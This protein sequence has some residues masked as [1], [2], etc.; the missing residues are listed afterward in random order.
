MYISPF[1]RGIIGLKCS[2]KIILEFPFSRPASYSVNPW[3]VNHLIDEKYFSFLFIMVFVWTLIFYHYSFLVWFLDHYQTC[4]F[5]KTLFFHFNYYQKL[6]IFSP[7]VVDFFLL[8][9]SLDSSA[10]SSLRYHLLFHFSLFV[11]YYAFNT[12]L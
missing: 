9:P 10:I 12:I 4:S 8:Y 7:S 2:Y 1:S 3:G 6:A 11:F 5:K